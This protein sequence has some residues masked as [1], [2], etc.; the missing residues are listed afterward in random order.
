MTGS[1]AY[2]EGF[3]ADVFISYARLDDKPVLGDAEGWVSQFHAEL[4]NQLPVYLGAEAEIWRDREEIRNNEDFSKKIS[5]QLESTA[6]FVAIL[7]ESFIHREWCLR[8]LE[9]FTNH[10]QQ[11][12]GVYVD[13]DKKRIFSIERMPMSRDALPSQ[14][15]GTTTYRFFEGDRILR[16]TINASHRAKYLASVEDLLIDISRVLKLLAKAARAGDIAPAPEEPK[17]TVYLAQTTSELDDH[18][19][20]MR[21]DLTER[22]YRVLPVGDLPPRSAR[23]REEVRS[24]LAKCALSIHLIGHDYGFVPE[25]EASKSNV[26][27][28]H[29]MALERAQASDLQPIVWVAGGEAGDARQRAF[30]A[31]LDEDDVVQSHAEILKNCGLEE[32]KTETYDKLDRIRKDWAKKA[33]PEQAGPVKASFAGLRPAPDE[34]PMIYVM[35]EEGSRKSP[36]LLAM[37]KYLLAKGY[38]PVFLEKLDAE[39]PT[40]Q[41]HIDNLT[42]CDAC[43]IYYDRKSPAW[44]AQKL[45]DLRKYLRGRERP[46]IAKAIYQVAAG[47]D[48]E[49]IETNAALVLRGRGEFAPEHLQPFVERLDALSGRSVL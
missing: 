29:E 45:G 34:P 18:A 36:P 37:R 5:H 43:I 17:M 22:G 32:L 2:V 11:R 46:V 30:M 41:Q 38:D 47:D 12:Y 27:L 7:S 21:R 25:G 26:W 48:D 35:C 15:E 44:L 1:K 40:L 19:A 24:C 23:F 16:P 8:E 13:G 49:A 3:E 9:E 6:T 31:Y 28:Q 20:E 39:E 33:E 42:L 10:A 14:L 4:V